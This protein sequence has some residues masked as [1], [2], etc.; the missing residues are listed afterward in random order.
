LCISDARKNLDAVLNRV[1]KGEDI[2]IIAGD[3]IIQ[4]RPVEVVA[5][6][7]SY[8]YQEYNL[9]SSEWARFKRRMAGRRT[10][11]NYATFTGAFDAKTFA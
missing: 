11:N 10:K 9:T 2:G 1:K 6:E 4:L 5:W 3:R 8:L 7:E